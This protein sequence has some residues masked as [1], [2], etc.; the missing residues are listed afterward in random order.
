MSQ[1]QS[2]K[3]VVTV[4]FRPD[5]KKFKEVLDLACKLVS[6]WQKTNFL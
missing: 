4:P 1:V 6:V 5:S 2:H 3:I